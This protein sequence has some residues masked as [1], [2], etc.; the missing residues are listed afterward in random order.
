MNTGNERIRSQN[1]LLSTITYRLQTRLLMVWKGV[2]LLPA[3]L[4]NG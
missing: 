4:C 2:F 3:L 1:R